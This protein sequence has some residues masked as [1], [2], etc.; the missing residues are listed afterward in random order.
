MRRPGFTLIEIL[1]AVVLFSVVAS[2]GMYVFSAQNRS[3]KTET[4]KVA[5]QMMAKGILDELSRAVR[6]TGSGLPE[7]A[8]GLKVYAAG[9]EMV[10]FVTND[11]GQ[12]DTVKGW[13]WVPGSGRLSI[14]VS[15]ARRFADS[16]YVQVSLMVPN[17]G[18][19]G[20][21]TTIRPFVLG[22]VDRTSATSGGCGDSVILDVTSLEQAPNSWNVAGDINAVMLSLVQNLDSITYR[23]SNDTLFVKRNA[24]QQTAFALGVDSLQLWYFH[25]VEGWK[26]SLS[27][28]NPADVISKV[29]I[30]LVMRSPKIDFKLKK[31][32]PASRGYRF[33]RL[34]TEVGLRTSPLANR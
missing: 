3:W 4:D 34:E 15:D 23:K 21:I 29:R 28:T 24:L 9:E 25:P 31:E 12:A 32:I 33:S 20:G 2:M 8:G 22:V 1:V 10:T 30:R 7:G 11:D 18:V 5:V 6:T 17:V 19:H 14:A 26:D 16:G 27:G 13:S